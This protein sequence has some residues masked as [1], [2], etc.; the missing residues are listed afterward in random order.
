MA[1]KYV[2]YTDGSSLGN[3]GPGGFAAVIVRPGQ[4][5]EISQGYR[6]T[7]NNRM[8][9]LAAVAALRYLGSSPC[10]V[11]L[12]TDSRL[13]VDTFEKHW[14]DSWAKK[15]WIK[16]DRQPV[17]NQ[18]LVKELYSLTKLHKVKFSWVKAHA[19]LPLNERCDELSKSA[20]ANPTE[21]DYE[22]EGITRPAGTSL[23]TLPAAQPMQNVNQHTNDLFSDISLDN[24]CDKEQ[25]LLETTGYNLALR[26]VEGKDC[27]VVKNINN[28]KIVEFLISDIKSLADKINKF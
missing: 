11:T 7:T 15:G 16:S 4:N 10:E 13:L 20:A 18:D 27:L 28:G 19:G 9:F 25:V 14:V 8:E 24:Q 2:I 26:R 5:I 22:Y 3:P 6:K 21:I 12:H 17:L 1:D 23:L